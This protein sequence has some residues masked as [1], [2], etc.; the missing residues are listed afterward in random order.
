[1]TYH[2][3]FL[4]LTRLQSEEDYLHERL[5]EE[6][7][8][9]WYTDTERSSRKYSY[10]TISQQRKSEDF[11]YRRAAQDEARRKALKEFEEQQE[12]LGRRVQ[13][14]LT[15]EEKA[16]NRVEAASLVRKVSE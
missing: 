5:F 12:R 7:L 11:K 9:K 14:W 10:L 15:W 6:R 2:N 4:G 13:I 8:A 3:P 16:Q 1:M